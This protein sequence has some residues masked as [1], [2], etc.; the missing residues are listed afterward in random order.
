M[1]DCAAKHQLNTA[2]HG[3]NIVSIPGLV[4][5]PEREQMNVAD[6]VHHNHNMKV[7]GQCEGNTGHR[8]KTPQVQH[9]WRADFFRLNNMT[10]M[11]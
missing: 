7:A 11:K 6:G 1:C 3:T 2:L 8:G 5:E 10:A 4:A 9:F